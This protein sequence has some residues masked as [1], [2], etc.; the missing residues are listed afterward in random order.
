MVAEYR[1]K[2]AIRAKARLEFTNLHGR[3]VTQPTENTAVKML[4][5]RSTSLYPIPFLFLFS[6]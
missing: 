3:Y 5:A 1:F 4:D 2:V 6:L